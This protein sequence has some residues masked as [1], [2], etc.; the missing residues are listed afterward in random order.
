MDV[1]NASQYLLS[2]TSI[3]SSAIRNGLQRFGMERVGKMETL[4]EIIAE[5]AEPNES[6]TTMQPG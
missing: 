3:P 1:D 5:M 6:S 2:V 4:Q